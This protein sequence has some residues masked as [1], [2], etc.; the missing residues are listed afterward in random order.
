MSAS[1]PEP[2][3]A[4]FSA[5]ARFARNASLFAFFCAKS[6]PPP[7]GLNRFFPT[8]HV[9]HLYEF[10]S[11]LKSPPVYTYPQSM[12][13]YGVRS[14]TPPVVVFL[15]KFKNAR[16]VVVVVV[17]ARRPRL[18]IARAVAPSAPRAPPRE[19]VDAR[20]RIVH[21][22]VDAIAIARRPLAGVAASVFGDAHTH[23][24]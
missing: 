9:G 11:F 12:H 21:V 15:P 2:R 24:R 16:V 23:V 4:L 20:A 7:C 5:A 3:A 1:R 8:L 13:R 6:D 22:D 19:N 14:T 18:S 17:R 10:G